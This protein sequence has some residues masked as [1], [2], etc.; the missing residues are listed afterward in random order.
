MI[1]AV[2][3]FVSL[4][5]LPVVVPLIIAMEMI[6][7]GCPLWSAITGLFLSG[8]MITIPLFHWATRE[9]GRLG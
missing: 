7:L 9:F 4:V 1:R 5:F 3:S 2:L 8:L 6:Q